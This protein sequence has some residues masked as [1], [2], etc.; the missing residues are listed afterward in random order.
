MSIYVLRAGLQTLVQAGPRRGHRHL[1]VPASGAADPLSLA[2]ANRLVG[3]PLDA[4]ALEAALLGPMLTFAV[5]AAVAVT[6][7]HAEV[8]LNGEPVDAH[9]THR[10]DADDTLDVAAAEEGARVYIAMAGGIEARDVLGS[11]ST[12][13]PAGLGGFD[14]R[15]LEDGDRLGILSA[16]PDV[17]AIVTPATHRPP[18]SNRRAIRVCA[19]AET[20]L[21]NDRQREVLFETTWI[22]GRRADRMGVALEGARIDIEHDGRMPSVP[23]FPGTIQCPNDGM[24]YLLGIDSGTTGGY[25]RVAQVARVDRHIIGQ[26]RPGDHVAFLPRTPDEALADLEAMHGYWRNWLAG[27]E[28]VI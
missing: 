13:A 15:A 7:A 6:G 22:V 26:L 11:T 16:G 3:N 23:V 5:P 24:P 10:V 17:E 2:I 9:R 20:S 12:Y 25:P 27:I 14:G 21:L 18:M 19:S 1:G 8:R 4:P 28:T